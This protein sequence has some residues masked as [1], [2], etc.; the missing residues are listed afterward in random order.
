[1]RLITGLTLTF[2]AGLAG[3]CTNLGLPM[4]TVQD[5][6]ARQNFAAQVVDPTPAEGAPQAD[7]DMVDAAVD[8]YRNDDVKTAGEESSEQAVT[9]GF[10]PTN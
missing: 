9:L 4:S 5:V 1:M 7:A 10:V 3:G 2:V 8:R 6:S